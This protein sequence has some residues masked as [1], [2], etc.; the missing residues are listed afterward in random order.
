MT[1][2][3]LLS[4]ILAHFYSKQKHIVFNIP[5]FSNIDS[6]TLQT[7]SSGSI[8]RNKL[9][10]EWSVP[11]VNKYSQMGICHMLVQALGALLSCL[12]TFCH[13][14]H[15]DELIHLESNLLIALHGHIATT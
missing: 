6:Y 14:H 13:V 3:P 12:D 10:C 8:A 7:T 9:C 5:F 2:L 1:I 4:H 11:P 15:N